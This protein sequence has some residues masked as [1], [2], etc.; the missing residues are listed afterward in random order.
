[1]QVKHYLNLTNGLESLAH[2]PPG[3]PYG[4]IRVQSTTLE[5]KDW[6]KLF[7]RELDADLLL[8][9]A[10]GVTCY[11]YDRGTNRPYSKTVYLGIPV[12]KYVLERCWLDKSPAAVVSPGRR[13]KA[14]ID[15]T[16][17]AAAAY[18]AIFSDSSNKQAAI[19]KK[20]RYYKK[21]L[22][23]SE[24]KLIGVSC[25]TSHD[26]DYAFYSDLVK[27]AFCNG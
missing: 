15:I 16:Q 20:L 14:E 22:K 25:S 7:G 1:M 12:I 6:T 13:G 17:V 18:H 24:L 8:H 5:N 27:R 23:T 21:Y 10:L 19:R 2:I 4:F 9:L 11:F 3:E 26:G